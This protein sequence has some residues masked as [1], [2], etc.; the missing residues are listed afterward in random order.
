MLVAQGVLHAAQNI[1]SALSALAFLLDKPRAVN[2][3]AEETVKRQ[4]PPT[5]ALLVC[6]GIASAL[7]GLRVFRRGGLQ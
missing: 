6:T 2:H 4:M 7:R 5:P 3:V 1:G